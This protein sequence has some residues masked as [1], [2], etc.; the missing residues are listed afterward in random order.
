MAW[1]GEAS[2]VWEHLPQ[3]AMTNQ[4][5]VNSIKMLRGAQRKDTHETEMQCAKVLEDEKICGQQRTGRYSE[6]GQW[7]TQELAVCL[8]G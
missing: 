2:G 4:D 5:Y 7:L 3:I 1:G 8:L 6:G